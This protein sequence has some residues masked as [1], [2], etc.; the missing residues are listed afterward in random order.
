[1]RYFVFGFLILFGFFHRIT[2][3]EFWPITISRTWLHPERFEMSMLQ[4]PLL[5]FLLSIFHIFSFSD[6][7]HLIIVKIVF[8]IISSIGLF[9]Y[10]Y[11][12]YQTHEPKKTSDFNIVAWICLGLFA[13]SPVFQA[14]FSSVRSDQLACVFFSFFLIFCYRKNLKFSLLCLVLL[15][16]L[17]IKEI[18]F[19]VPGTVFLALEFRN[20]FTKR[21]LLFIGMTV[22]AALVWSIALNLD[23][24]FYLQETFQNTDLFARYGN[25]I[26]FFEY[27]MLI[28]G[29]ISAV[30]FIFRTDKKYFSISVVSILFLLILMA[31]PQSFEF[32]VASVVPFIYIP[33]LLMFLQLWK[34]YK[35]VICAAVFSQLAFVSWVKLSTGELFYESNLQQLHYISQAS[36]LLHK[37]RLSYLDGEGILPKQTYVP[38]FASPLDSIANQGCIDMLKRNRPDVVIVTNRLIAIGEIIFTLL[39]DDYTQVYPN[40]YMLNEYVTEDVKARINL[41]GEMGLPILIF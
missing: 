24:L 19:L 4:K 14:N 1:M 28:V 2:G 37:N 3:S 27:P 38:C 34:R 36:A 39:H 41:K 5:T 26:F 17:G 12:V 15:P 11:Y 6:V 18:I 13:V 9:A 10:A 35:I 30:Y 25:R 16:F 40:L 8:A 20:V 22:V 23:A 33:V 29:L 32:F 7:V 21:S 31:L